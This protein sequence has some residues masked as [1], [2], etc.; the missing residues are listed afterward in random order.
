MTRNDSLLGVAVHFH[1][2]N[3]S[4]E[5]PAKND[6]VAPRETGAQSASAFEY[7][8][9]DLA[10]SR[11]PSYQDS[12]RHSKSIALASGPHTHLRLAT[13]TTDA[14]NAPLGQ[15]ASPKPVFDGLHR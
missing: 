14:K 15:T 6:A 1:R 2:F 10:A 4:L 9:T 12:R 5:G 7:L 8:R 3:S 13:G 11:G